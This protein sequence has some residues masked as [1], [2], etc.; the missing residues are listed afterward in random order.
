MIKSIEYVAPRDA[1]CRIFKYFTGVDSSRHYLI[2]RD[3]SLVLEGG[4]VVKMLESV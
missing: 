2:V 1:D 3:P 4:K